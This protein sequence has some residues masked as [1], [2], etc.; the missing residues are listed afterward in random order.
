MSHSIKYGIAAPVT[1]ARPVGDVRTYSGTRETVY[2]VSFGRGLLIPFRR[3]GKGDFAN[4]S[5]ITVV[6][7]NVRQVLYTTAS[8][9][10]SDG[11]LPWRPEFG[12]VLDLLR[13]RNLDETT[14]ELARTHA[15]DALRVWVPQVQV[16]RTFVD[17][18]YDM[19]LLT[20]SVVYDILAA[21]KRSVLASN[22]NDSVN[23][24]VAA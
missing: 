19:K 7:S 1:T 14:F 12:S 24:A 16:K 6:R 17:V 5:D 10:I 9:S 22:V 20:L 3:D 15:L 4:A 21:S 8:S 11:E 18:D 23:I 13:F 2:P